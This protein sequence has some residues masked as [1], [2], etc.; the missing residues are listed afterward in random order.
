M[1]EETRGCAAS[2][3]K[4]AQSSHQHTFVFEPLEPRLLLSGDISPVASLAIVNGLHH[5][6]NVLQSLVLTPDGGSTVP[7]V[8]RRLADLAALGEPVAQL[9]TAASNYLANTKL[10]EAGRDRSARWRCVT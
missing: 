2:D 8:N 6:D 9:A 1:K 10:R 4:P 5:L 3:P 7:I